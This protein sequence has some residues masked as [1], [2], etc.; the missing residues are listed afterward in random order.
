MKFIRVIKADDNKKLLQCQKQFLQWMKKYQKVLSE[1]SNIV[2]SCNSAL[3][4]DEENVNG[5]NTMFDDLLVK[6]TN[7][8]IENITFDDFN[9]MPGISFDEAYLDCNNFIQ[10]A[11]NILNKQNK[12]DTKNINTLNDD[13][14]TFKQQ[15][16]TKLKEGEKKGIIDWLDGVYLKDNKVEIIYST[17]RKFRHPDEY[18][19]MRYDTPEELQEYNQ[20]EYEFDNIIS[21]F[22]KKH[23][24]EIDIHA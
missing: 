8:S 16:M 19:D 20:W 2:S 21:D 3:T 6:L 4:G 17:H 24:I 10:K 7:K 22:Q 14:N 12:K 1:L 15:L 9:F 11:E 5:F 23:N 18:F 13:F